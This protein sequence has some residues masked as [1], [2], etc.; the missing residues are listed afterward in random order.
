MKSLNTTTRTT[1]S[2]VLQELNRPAAAPVMRTLP[3]GTASAIVRGMRLKQ[4][5]KN[6]IIFAPLLF[7]GHL[8]EYGRACDAAGCFVAFCLISSGVYVVNDIVD[9]TADRQHPLK[10]FRPVASGALTIRMAFILASTL[11]LAGLAMAYLLRPTLLVVCLC[12][13]ALSLSYSLW[14]K[15]FAV[16]DAMIIAAG[17]LLRAVAGAVVVKVWLSSWL[18]VCTSLAALF[19]ALEKRRQELRLMPDGSLAHRISLKGYSVAL[20]SRLE[21]LVLP[22]LLTSYALWSFQAEHGVA[23]LTTFPFVLYGIMRYQFL[24]ERGTTTGA[25]EEVLWNDRPIQIT[26]A[27]WVA[28]C[29]VIIYGQP[30][31]W[32]ESLSRYIDSMRFWH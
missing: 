28:T 24:S 16:I 23:M 7:S 31:D 25:P 15:R 26:L 11:V 20:I 4:W 32:L 29:A 12:Y 1:A 5:P 3:E 2:P 21:G 9:V 18:L 19:L 6:L 27:L 17:F 22:S 14:L 30:A 13:I 8:L 10:R